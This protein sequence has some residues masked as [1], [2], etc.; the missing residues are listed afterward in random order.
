MKKLLSTLVLLMLLAPL[1]PASSAASSSTSIVDSGDFDGPTGSNYFADF[2]FVTDEGTEEEVTIVAENTTGSFGFAATETDNAIYMGST[3]PFDG[4][5]MDVD[6]GVQ[7]GSYKM[8]YYNG[9]SWETLASERSD[10]IENSGSADIFFLTWSRPS[11]WSK[12][13]ETVDSDLSP[14]LYWARLD[15][16][17]EYDGE[18]HI[19]QIGLVVFNLQVTVKNE[20]GDEMEDGLDSYALDTRSPDETIYAYQNAD[21]GVYNLALNA[22]SGG[23][24][25]YEFGVDGYVMEEGNAIVD[26]DQEDLSLILNYAYKVYAKKSDGTGLSGATVK[27]GDNYSVSCADLGSGEYGCPVALGDEGDGEFKVTKSGY[28]TQ[29]GSFDSARDSETDPQIKESVTVLAGS[30]GDDDEADLEVSSIKLNSSNEITFTF[31]NDSSVDV[32]ASDDFWVVVS[33]GGD[34][35]WD[36]EI[37]SGMDSDESFSYDTNLELTSKKTVKVCVDTDDDVNESDEDNNCSS[38]SLD[39]EDDDDDDDNNWG[40]L[41]DEKDKEIDCDDDFYDTSNSYAEKA[42]CLLHEA[43][44]VDGKKPHYYYP[45]RSVTRAEFLKMILLNAGENVKAD[46]DYD[47]YSDV[48]SSDWFYKYVTYGTKIGVV[49]GYRGGKFKPQDTINRV[50]AVTMI[51]RAAEADMDGI[52]GSDID[53]RDVSPSAWYAPYVELCY[54]LGII[55]GYTSEYFRPHKDLNRAEA[56]VLM[57]RVWYVY[58]EDGRID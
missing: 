38:K 50:E 18:A 57:R 23:T 25:Y 29:T 39:P 7:D 2:V 17:D 48:K 42:I 32:S 44:V 28:Q 24:F 11:D 55:E 40:R 26:Q 41:A 33:V 31:T 14:S 8:E 46:S 56:A 43:G 6:T 3:N 19:E 30:E 54:K 22:E 52:D 37:K 34:K 16:T 4:F 35:K 36:T 13:I 9:S 51:L 10:D 27:A 21:D 1:A 53:F 58:Y 47:D 5:S 49:E 12:L 45:Q 15:L 20:D